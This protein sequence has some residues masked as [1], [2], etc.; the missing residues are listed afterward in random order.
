MAT[1]PNRGRRLSPQDDRTPANAPKRANTSKPTPAE[2]VLERD[3]Q[4]QVIDLARTCGWMVYHAYAQ[5]SI[6]GSRAIDRGFPDLILARDGECLAIELKGTLGKLSDDQRRWLDALSQA[7]IVTL[8]CW[9]ADWPDIERLLT[10][11]APMGARMTGG[12]A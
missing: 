4:K 10:S 6:L 8:V 3:F 7:G 2:R 9:P 1:A 11:P 12:A 5:G